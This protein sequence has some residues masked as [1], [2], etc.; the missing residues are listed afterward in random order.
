MVF[1]YVLLGVIQGL[2]EFLPISSSGHLV[3]LHRLLDTA[4]GDI[5]FYII[6]HL[7][8]LCAIVLFCWPELKNILSAI[9]RRTYVKPGPY[10]KVAKFL[11]IASI[12]TAVI[13]I[14][15]D[16]F[17]ERMF[18]SLWVVGVSLVITGG[19]LFL[20]KFKQASCMR[21]RED[22]K[23]TDGAFIGLAQ[24][25]SLVPGLS[26]SAMTI[27]FCI[28]RG[29]EPVLAVRLSFLLA[30]PAIIGAGLYKIKEIT[31]VSID[32]GY[33]LI[34]FISAFVFSLLA[35]R[36]LLVL[37]SRF[38]FYHFAYYCWGLSVLIF[39]FLIRGA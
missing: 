32:F 30:I 7:G 10:L 29:I 16:N 33:L 12:F 9:L 21:Q 36:I 19:V 6:V 1:R 38:K 22:L 27:S 2:T 14:S 37:V 18:S 11:I 25:L 34:A 17:I 8:S 24:G 26:R 3:I 28:F 31:S 4:E 23:L 5:V 39:F 35:L 13:A 20:T 15:F